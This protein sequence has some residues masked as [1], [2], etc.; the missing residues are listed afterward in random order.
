M[1][2]RTCVSFKNIS[3][4]YAFADEVSQIIGDDLSCYLGSTSITIQFRNSD[5]TTARVNGLAKYYDGIL[6]CWDTDCG[7]DKSQCSL[8]AHP[9]PRE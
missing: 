5:T 3:N 6:G 8:N 4:A 9:A 2:F 1:F 7:L